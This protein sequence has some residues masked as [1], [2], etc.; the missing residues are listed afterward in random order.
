METVRVKR[1]GVSWKGNFP[2]GDEDPKKPRW[3]ISPPALVLIVALTMVVYN[4][5]C[6][7]SARQTL[8]NFVGSVQHLYH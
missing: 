5:I 4:L 6:N 2:D 7:E 3:T 1:P 8:M